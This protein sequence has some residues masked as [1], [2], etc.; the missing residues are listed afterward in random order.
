MH[1]RF[2][3]YSQ[4]LRLNN[5]CWMM[6]LLIKIIG[7][8]MVNRSW[9]NL[10]YY[11]VIYLEGLR[12]LGNTSVRIAG[13]S[14]ATF[15]RSVLVL[16]VLWSM[17]LMFCNFNAIVTSVGGTPRPILIIWR[18][19]PGYFE[20]RCYRSQGNA[21]ANTASRL[22]SLHTT[23]SCFLEDWNS[24]CISLCSG[25]DFGRQNGMYLFHK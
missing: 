3:S 8:D 15:G 23:L 14:A 21:S 11:P 16:T 6:G 19:I 12:N 22:V 13:L 24:S 7:K 9:P 25:N 4:Y 10:N 5:K 17:I 1:L 18:S 2:I 20:R